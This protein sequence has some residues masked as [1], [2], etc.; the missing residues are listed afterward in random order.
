M[1]KNSSWDLVDAAEEKEFDVSK[2]DKDQLPEE[3]KT[4]S[5]KE[6]ESYIA[7]KKKERNLIQQKIQDLNKKRELFITQNQKDSTSGELENAML[8]A[9]K[10]QAEKKNYKWD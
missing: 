9:I 5:S 4:K 1:Y 2:I 3:L 7:D 8:A 10:K 6:I